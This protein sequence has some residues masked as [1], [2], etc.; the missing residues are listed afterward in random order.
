MSFAWLGRIPRRALLPR[1]RSLSTSHGASPFYIQT[2]GQSSSEQFLLVLPQQHLPLGRIALRALPPITTVNKSGPVPAFFH[3][4]SPEEIKADWAVFVENAG[5]REVLQGV[6][7]E[8]IGREELM[9]NEARRL[10][11]GDGWIHLCDER[12]LPAYF[13]PPS[14]D[15]L[16]F[17]LM[18]LLCV[19]IEDVCA[20]GCVCF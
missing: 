8:N 9:V 14:R 11:G 7:R 19:S 13:S 2:F 1:H 4:I 6:V 3:A 15:V 17:S 20:D 18:G 5:F 10:P 12:N 16:C